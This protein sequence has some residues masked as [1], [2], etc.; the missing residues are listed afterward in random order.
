MRSVAKNVAL[1]GVQGL[2][3]LSHHLH[4]PEPGLKRG[5]NVLIDPHLRPGP[6]PPACSQAASTY[7]PVHSLWHGSVCLRPFK[8]RCMLLHTAAG[9]ARTPHCQVVA[10]PEAAM[11]RG[12]CLVHRLSEEDGGQLGSKGCMVDL[13]LQAAGR[14]ATTGCWQTCNYR[15]LAGMHESCEVAGRCSFK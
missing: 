13:Q 2:P 5:L 15:L 4:G 3:A 12:S 10:L 1:V 7:M 8:S 14:P 11:C 9:A 6:L